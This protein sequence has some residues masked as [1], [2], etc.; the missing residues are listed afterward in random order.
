MGPE[1]SSPWD[2]ARYL[3]FEAE[4]TLP[5]RDLI[6]RLEL[7]AP[8]RVVDLGCGPGTSTAVLAARWPDARLVGVDHSRE[9]LRRARASPL[10]IEWVEAD[11]AEWTPEAPFDLVFSNA[12]LHW[13][14]GHRTLLPRLW[15]WVAPGGALAFQVPARSNPSPAWRRAV[16][17]VAR[18]S[19]WSAHSWDDPAEANVLGL[20]AY[21][22]LL[23][24]SA[25]RLDLWDTEYDHVLDGPEAV[26]DWIRGT[27]LRPGLAQ[28]PG[29]AERA[30]FLG[31][32]TREIA[33]LYPRRP[34][35]KVLFPFLRRF[36]VAYR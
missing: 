9:M 16:A 26:V 4:R 17:S 31:E 32:L 18:R 6:R 10:G 12:A 36:V 20:D 13:L 22:D 25:R 27:A 8:R 21:Y 23:S 34:D 29:E 33:G 5:C 19:P 15:N 30:R 2:S 1:A 3:R 28:L 35:G 24:P 14:P 11:L 7:D